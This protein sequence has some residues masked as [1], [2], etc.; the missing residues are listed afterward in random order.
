MNKN[1]YISELSSHLAALS[2]TERADILRDVEEHF[3]EANNSGQSEESVIQ[4]LGKP[5]SFADMMV[6]ETKV[7]RINNATTLGK[8]LKAVASAALTIL[9]L[10]PF[11]LIFILFP[12][13]LATLFIGII[14]IMVLFFTLSIPLAIVSPIIFIL[15]IG[16]HLILLSI[17]VLLAAGWC[18][19]VATIM[20]LFYYVALLYVRV[21]SALFSWNINFVKRSLRS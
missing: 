18:G 13:F 15:T 2:E 3:R 16:F 8:K 10:A 5:T 17:V 19:L 11:N 14:G 7:N 21:I 20:I 12:L 1:Q 9:I 6:A 4:Q